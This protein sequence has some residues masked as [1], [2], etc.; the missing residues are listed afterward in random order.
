MKDERNRKVYYCNPVNI[1]Y[2]YQFYKMSKVENGDLVCSLNLENGIPFRVTE[3]KEN[4]YL[5][6]RESADPSVIMF[7]GKYYMFSSMSLGVHVSE[8]MVNWK[9]HKL[10]PKLPLNDYSPDACVIDDH[11]YICASRRDSSC[12]FYRTE[13]ILEGPY[14]EIKMD[15]PFYDPNLFLDDDGRLYLYYGCSNT[16]PIYGIELSRETLQPI[17][18]R[19]ELV[20]TDEQHIGFQRY[21]ENHVSPWSEEQI[22]E[23]YKQYLSHLGKDDAELSEKERKRLRR[24]IGNG[25]YIE[26]AW[27]TKNNGKYYL[28]TAT[29]GTQFN[30]YNDCV[31]VSENP[32]GPFRLAD[33]NPFSYHPGGYITGAGHGSTFA[34]RYGDW[35]HAAS[36]R[37]SVNHCFE[38]RVGIWPAGFDKDGEL[39]CNQRYGDWPIAV[40][41][42]EKKDPF[43]EPEWYLLS[44]RKPVKASSSAPG[45][46]P[47]NTADED[48]RTWWCADQCETG[49]WIEMD[50]GRDYDVRAVQVNFADSD[51]IIPLPEGKIIQGDSGAERYIDETDHITGWKLEGS[52]DGKN[53]FLIMDKSDSR[54]NHPHDL[55]VIEEGL[56]VRFLRVTVLAQPYQQAACISGLRVF[57]L[58]KGEKPQI[59]EFQARRVNDLDMEVEIQDSGAIGYNILWGSSPD[60]LY[61]SC[62]VFGTELRIGALIKDRDYFVRV[63]AFNESGITEGKVIRLLREPLFHII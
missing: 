34:D 30:I 3:G 56:A 13:N 57:G 8:D 60:K 62:M 36:M 29:T 27:M 55:C 63:D 24:L 5:L 23:R 7:K 18:D 45:H 32:L 19:K 21:G 46:G 42:T 47:E 49:E 54:D 6:C 4:G 33:N 38:R 37:I 53:Y 2:K 1:D 50:L 40:G 10:D 59:P 26:G 15:F 61:H 35:Y 9:Y 44:Y 12:S 31:F 52:Q 58:G 48:S 51:L 17:G 43:S 14:E 20:W 39:F 16:A 41:D 25:T 11:V 28:Q 22:G